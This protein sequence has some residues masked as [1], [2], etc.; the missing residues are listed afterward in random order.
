MLRRVFTGILVA[1]LCSAAGRGIVQAFG[2]DA[3]VAR[4]IR[5]VATWI[6]SNQWIS[7]A[8][9][10]LFGL[11]GLAVWELFR[12][13]ERLRNLLVARPFNADVRVSLVD[14]GKGPLGM[15]M[16]VYHSQNGLTAS[17]IRFLLYVQ[18]ANRQD[19]PAKID[20]YSVAISN[21][22]SGPW[23]QLPNMNL[24]T[25]RVFSIGVSS[26][27]STAQ[28]EPLRYAQQMQLDPLLDAELQRQVPAR[29]SIAG[30]AAFDRPDEAHE[31]TTFFKVSLRDIGGNTIATVSRDPLE[32]DGH[33]MIGMAS[34]RAVGARADLSSVFIR[35]HRDQ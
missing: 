7:W 17:P 2:L 4:M 9:A 11:A 26:D 6:P 10:G 20:S 25:M 8:L 35:R 29:D 22:R 34:M 23:Q 28:K 1:V 16:G 14:V 21:S 27:Q 15:F 18:I 12:V 30:W 13:D 31:L 24:I 19:V 3:K 5:A 32:S 33:T